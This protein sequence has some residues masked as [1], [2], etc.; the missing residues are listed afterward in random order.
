[1]FV[2]TP[3]VVTI[4]LNELL[5]LKVGEVAYHPILEVPSENSPPAHCT[6]AEVGITPPPEGPSKE[7]RGLLELLLVDVQMVLKQLLSFH[8]VYNYKI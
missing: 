1:M 5:Q 7:L 6:S 3:M 4:S 2:M 8:L